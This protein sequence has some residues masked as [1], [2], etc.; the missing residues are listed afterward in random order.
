MGQKQ[1]KGK[2]EVKGQVKGTKLRRVVKGGGDES[3]YNYNKIAKRQLRRN[4]ENE[5]GGVADEGQKLLESHI[6]LA[7]KAEN[8]SIV[9]LKL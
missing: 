4:L 1:N 6:F 3:W 9:L 2:E 5:D 7:S 8:V